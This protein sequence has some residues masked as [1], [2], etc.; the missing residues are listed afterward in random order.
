MTSGANKA[1]NGDRSTKGAVKNQKI[2]KSAR[3]KNLIFDIKFLT[4]MG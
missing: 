3:V 4:R 1:N 2:Q